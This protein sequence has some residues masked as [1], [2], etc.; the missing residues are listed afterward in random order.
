ML[1]LPKIVGITGIL[2]FEAK[3]E[4]RNFASFPEV[5]LKRLDKFPKEYEAY[6]NDNFSLRTP[7][8]ELYHHIKFHFLGVTPHA[9]KTIIGKKGWY[10]LAGETQEVF[11][12][13]KGFSDDE[14]NRFTELWRNRDSYFDS[15][16]ISYY[17]MV[18]PTK[19]DIYP[20]Y[21]PINIIPP[22]GKTRF[23]KLKEHLGKDFP[24]LII[25]PRPVLLEAKKSKKVFYQLDNHWTFL[26]GEEVAK[27]L[28]SRLREDFPMEIIED[29]P[30]HQWDIRKVQ[31]G[32]HYRTLGI[33]DLHEYS[34]YPIR[35]DSA[36]TEYDFPIPEKFPYPDVYQERF[37]WTKAA[38]DLKALF[39]IDSFG[40]RLIPFVSK[41][42]LESVFIFDNWSYE[43]NKPIVEKIKPDIVIYVNLET[44]TD[45][46]LEDRN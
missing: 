10:F 25:D 17:W 32:I 4:N 9:K 41:S 3:K 46:F 40:S 18:A 30:P 22:S 34:S 38:N 21:L 35:T 8:L 16:G 23:D 15:L 7:L 6:I 44:H 12:G 1:V 20:E 42:F 26:A 29:C 37:V 5:D 19:Y 27:Q 2:K 45:H 43:L 33:K 36:A 39:I 11:E 24:E 28:L 14:L 13:R 31:R